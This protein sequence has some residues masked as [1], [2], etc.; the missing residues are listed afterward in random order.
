MNQHLL[1][2]NV[3][4]I[5]KEETFHFSCHPS[6]GCFTDCCRQLELAL[7]PYDIL[8]LKKGLRPAL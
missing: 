7:T 3:T 1:P 4:R 2:R 5:E 6:I 8:R